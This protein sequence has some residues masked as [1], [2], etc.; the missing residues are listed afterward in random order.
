MQVWGSGWRSAACRHEVR[1]ECARSVDASDAGLCPHEDSV[2]AG[3]KT[4]SEDAASALKT[5]QCNK[6][7]LP[8]RIQ[9]GSATCIVFALSMQKST[10][11][12]DACSRKSLKV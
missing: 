11:G 9:F 7:N 12:P 8:Q 10:C 2:D 1:G 5:G 3:M 6:L 4:S